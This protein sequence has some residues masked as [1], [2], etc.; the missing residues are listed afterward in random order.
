[1]LTTAQKNRLIE[2]GAIKAETLENC[3]KNDDPAAPL[4]SKLG[5]V[6]D[7]KL[8][9]IT[10]GFDQK[11]APDHTQ[12]I[13]E[14]AF[15]T[16]LPV[17]LSLTEKRISILKT[18]SDH[19]ILMTLYELYMEG[20][21][22]DPDLG[23]DLDDLQLTKDVKKH[24]ETW[25][26]VQNILENPLEL[27]DDFWNDIKTVDDLLSPSPKVQFNL[28]SRYGTS[29]DDLF[30]AAARSND[31]DKILD[32]YKNSP[33]L[34]PFMK[35]VECDPERDISIM[36]ILNFKKDSGMVERL[37]EPELWR[38]QIEDLN[39]FWQKHLPERIKA[40]IT[41]HDALDNYYQ[42]IAREQVQKT[43]RLRRRPKP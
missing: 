8:R 21:R 15:L 17:G 5:G 28:R 34:F 13:R 6:L 18:L 14:I 41:L 35:L 22:L 30:M 7:V 11:K 26:D 38:G 16:D 40:D 23:A 32:I 3:L 9:E 36:D 25:L 39:G 1:M 2:M 29:C 10:R 24:L 27:E 42:Y 33:E 12:A 37:L 19:V 4:N 31:F 43:T 20:V